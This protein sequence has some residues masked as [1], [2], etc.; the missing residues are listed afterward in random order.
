MKQ[1]LIL[2]FAAA[3]FTT[4]CGNNNDQSAASKPG[5]N[6]LNAPADY[7]SGLAKGQQVAV[8]TID[9][10]SINSAIQMFEATEGRYPK[11][12]NELVSKKLLPSVPAPPRGMKFNYDSTTGTVRV[13]PDK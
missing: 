5:E 11:D 8:K 2:S 4:G 10:A 1:W 13:V 7:V 9:T 12:L 3:V 6:P